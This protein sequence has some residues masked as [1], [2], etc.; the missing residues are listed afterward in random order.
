[1]TASGRRGALRDGQ[2]RAG[3]RRLIAPGRGLRGG[4]DRLAGAPSA[5]RGVPADDQGIADAAL[6]DLHTDGIKARQPQDSH[7]PVDRPGPG[8]IGDVPDDPAARRQRMGQTLANLTRQQGG[9][10]F[11]AAEDIDGDRLPM[12]GCR[13]Q[14]GEGVSLNTLDIGRKLKPGVCEVECDGGTVDGRDPAAST[15]ELGGQGPARSAQQQKTLG[16]VQRPGHGED[17]F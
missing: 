10:D 13:L 12:A 11:G 14:E 17:V 7:D 15:R 8:P 9:R 2:E 5:T 4:E 16:I 3:R 1:M 6:E